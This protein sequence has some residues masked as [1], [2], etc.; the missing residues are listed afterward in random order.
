MNFRLSLAVLAVCG[1]TA[2]AAAQAP[3]VVRAQLLKDTNTEFAGDF[4]AANNFARVGNAVYFSASTPSTGAEL[5]T[6]SGAAGDVRLVA[7]FVPG[8]DSSNPRALGNAGAALIVASNTPDFQGARLWAVTPDARVLLTPVPNGFAWSQEF[9]RV[10]GQVDDRLVL[11]ALDTRKIWTTD[12]TVA[13][14]YALDDDPAFPVAGQRLG[15]S[16]QLPGAVIFRA[17]DLL[18]EE[19]LVRT[20][21]TATGTSVLRALGATASGSLWADRSPVV[22]GRCYLA[23]R[24][25]PGTWTLWRS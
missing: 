19:R 15:E 3:P 22:D 4:G 21:G 6:T 11:Q 1:W 10:L 8:N 2:A 16:C 17:V 12:G 20:D 24:R 5:F 7:D 18:N 13:G 9:V 25:A 23:S 14:T